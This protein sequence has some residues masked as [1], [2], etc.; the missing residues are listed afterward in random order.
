LIFVHCKPKG[1][2][3]K[4]N[5]LLKI[6]EFGQSI[7]LDFLRRKMIVSG[8][9]KELI[10][11]DGLRGMT[12]NPSIFDKVIAGSHDY[13]DQI[14]ALALEGRSTQE[15]YEALTVKDVQ[16][17]A[18]LFRAVFEESKGKDGFVSLEVNPHLAHDV[19]GTLSEARRLWK[20]LNRPN[21]F[22]KVPATEEGLKCIRRLI[23]ERINVNVT[24][25]FGL[26]RYREVAEAY[27][28]GLEDRAQKGEPL[29]G[30]S[31]VA[32]LFLS[33]IDV[34]VDPML[35]D[36]LDAGGEKT[37]LVER[38]HG[39]IAISSAK[40]AYQIYKETFGSK[41][42]R[43]LEEKGAQRQR[44]LWA[45]TSTKNP[46]YSDV[47]YVEPL[48]G[49]QTINT[50]P[51]E[52]LNAY[53]DHGNP[54]PRLE[55]GIEEAM[56]V[57]ELLQELRIDIDQVTQQ[58]EDEGIEKFNQPYDDLMANLEEKRA[59]ALQE[60][61]DLQSLAM[62]DYEGPVRDTLE[63][64]ERESFSKRLWRKDPT[65]W[66]SKQNERD[67]ICNALG[68][69]HVAEKMEKNIKCLQDFVR[70]V[71]NAE[72]RHVVH[73]GMGGSSLAP[74]AFRRIFPRG[75]GGLP[76]TV[77]DTTD[78]VTVGAIE[79]RVPLEKTL[80]IVASKSGTT[81]EPLAFGEYFYAK[82]KEV[83]G[84]R[85]GENFAVITDPGSPLTARARE[86]KYRRVF[87]NYGDIGGRY[88][89]L[90]Y[91]GLVP[92]ALYGLDVEELLLRSLRM[93]H[94]C[95]SSVDVR[96]NPG[97]VLGA[98]LGELALRG[99]NKVTLL[100]PE[101]MSPL[102]MWIEQ[103]LAESTGKKGRGLLPVASEP[104]GHPSVYGNDRMFVYFCI[105]Q[106]LD[107]RLERSVQRLKQAKHPVVTIVLEDRKDLSQ[108]FFR[109]EIA[110]ATAGSILEINP[111]DQPN[112]QESKDNTNQLLKVVSETGHLPKE[113]PSL[114]EEPLKLYGGSDGQDVTTSFF[115]FFSQ[116]APG[117]YVAILAY[118]TE[119]TA[120]ENALRAL[121][122][123]VQERI[124]MA[125]TLGY[126]PRYLH[127]T[128]QYHKGGPNKG[129][130]VLV[131]AGHDAD[132]AIPGSP[133]GFSAF[134]EAQALGDFQALQKHG[135]R[136]LRVHLGEDVGRGIIRFREVL[137]EALAKF[138]VA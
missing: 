7:W 86:R 30:I 91:F 84:D 58:L 17:A 57:L 59:A 111:F 83:K 79:N 103:L 124:R 88:S 18:D 68:W 23:S 60:R 22:I 82:V 121:C 119:E 132:L 52:T 4:K 21:V 81:A 93:M 137:Q 109:W 16:D 80:F 127:S 41:R 89:A 113:N 75:T 138:P 36:M 53:R 107:D 24:L 129:L 20:E 101:A 6:Q 49:P 116:A 47:K 55:E 3:M 97:L 136:I 99:R 43:K 9:L 61:V 27:I 106:E 62:G 104:V 46:A 11:E 69:L 115:H 31:S 67:V 15:I 94:A 28:S 120:T 39:Q 29:E 10:E 42:F 51:Q 78:A 128:G 77:L 70:E 34:L 126:G 118:L 131:T 19:E 50:V 14:R 134:R 72:F 12:S 125:T 96:E 63:R 32:S 133:Y 92:A 73:M 76:L 2:T 8:E 45:S 48:I 5:P 85:A 35:E 95:Q 65:L 64:L 108:E 130:F 100:L 122:Q 37:G 33:R 40:E 66:S 123:G 102:G 105:R 38:A 13:D 1:K 25:L 110:T 98:A 74:L 87:L 26:S 114:V 44:V 112:V 135:R 56:E 71:K 117:D 90:S 54:A